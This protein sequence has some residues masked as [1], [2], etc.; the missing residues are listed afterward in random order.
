M[1][2]THDLLVIATLI[3]TIIAGLIVLGYLSGRQ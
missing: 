1:L 2:T 3:A